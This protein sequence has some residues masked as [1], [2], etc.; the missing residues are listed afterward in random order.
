M[1]TRH[2]PAFAL[3]MM[4][5]ATLACSR[6]GGELS[7]TPGQTSAP[8]AAVS[9]TSGPAPSE[10]PLASP[11]GPRRLELPPT[12][13]PFSVT[14]GDPRA[15][16]D[17]SHPTYVD[18]FDEPRM[19]FDYDTAGRAAYRVEDGHL[20][21][22][23]YEPEERYSW[24]SYTDKQSDNVYAE[25]SATNGDCINKD[26]VGFVIHS[27]PVTASGGYAL[28]V[29]CDG[30][31]R[32]RLHRTGASPKDLVPW[33]PSEVIHQGNGATNRL[34][35]WDHRRRFA[36]FINGQQVGESSDPLNSYP[37][38][39][40]AV[41]VRASQTYNLTATFDDLAFW[42]LPYVLP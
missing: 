30:N 21:G 28:E 25:I 38:G 20:I 3:V 16:L 5:A 22:I 19:W 6:L 32:L 18:Y 8:G 42:Q 39:T 40:F 2:K 37:F 34:G 17:L 41:Y 27:D 24:W 14:A 29:S 7:A 26:S 4:L 10:A 12:P 36:L 11:T 35:F 13:T 33:T 9:G 15:M 31:W 23:D 1:N